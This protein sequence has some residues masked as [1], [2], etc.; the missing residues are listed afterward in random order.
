[1]PASY[2]AMLALSAVLGLIVITVAS[3]TTGSRTVLAVVGAVACTPAAFVI[4]TWGLR[5]PRWNRTENPQVTESR[6]ISG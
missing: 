6:S 4:V 5:G 1:M 3:I 2:V